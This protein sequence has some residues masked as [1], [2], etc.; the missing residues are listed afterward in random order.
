MVAGKDGADRRPKPKTAGRPGTA[1]WTIVSISQA[2]LGVQPELDGL[3]IDP[4]IPPEWTLLTLTRR[5]RGAQYRITVENPDGAEHG[6]RELYVDGVQQ[7]GKPDR[8]RRAGSV[9]SVRVVLGD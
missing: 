3:R 9:V 4:C 6:V 5:F 2:I 8:A 1:A 7:T